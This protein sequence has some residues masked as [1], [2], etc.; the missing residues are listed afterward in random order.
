MLLPGFKRCGY[1]HPAALGAASGAERSA[2]PD[3]ARSLNSG[4][5]EHLGG[6]P[7]PSPEIPWSLTTT[8]GLDHLFL[9]RERSL[10]LELFL[11]PEDRDAHDRPSCESR[12]AVLVER[13]VAEEPV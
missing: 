4:R 1:P 7:R 3:Q 6:G 11:A 12:I 10:D 9:G 2:L 13:E 5:S 8:S